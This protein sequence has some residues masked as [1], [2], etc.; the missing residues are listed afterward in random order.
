MANESKLR[1]LYIYKILNEM[2]DESHPLYTVQIMDILKRNYGIE[3]HRTTVAEDV[4][5]LQRFGIDIVKIRSTQSKYFIGNRLF[6][7]P[8]LKILLDAVDSSKTITRSKSRLLATKLLSLTDKFSASAL[9]ESMRSGEK[10]KPENEQIYYIV[11]AI[12][13]AIRQNKKISFRYFQY[14]AKKERVLRH[15]GKEYVFSPFTT[16]WNGDFYYIIGVTDQHPGVSTFR[17]DRIA[18]R[19]KILEE[20]ADPMPADFSAEDYLRST[21]RMFDS[22]HETVTL[23]CE[24]DTLDSL[25]DR[26]GEEIDVKPYDENTFLATVDIALSHIFYNWVFGFCGKIHILK[27]ENALIEYRTMLENALESMENE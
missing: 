14:N 5:V 23:Q 25:I 2:T 21:F 27:P 3:S 20:N 8:E 1:L 13:M 9:R 15:N 4:E 12:E 18:E 26:F 22:K 16:V 10:V 7:M 6:Q 19:P 11:D 24:N 17:V